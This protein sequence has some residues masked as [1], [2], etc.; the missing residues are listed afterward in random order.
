MIEVLH[1]PSPIGHRP[2]A[3]HDSAVVVTAMRVACYAALRCAIAPKHSSGT[4]LS[5]SDICT[6]ALK[7]LSMSDLSTHPCLEHVPDIARERRDTIVGL[8]EGMV[9]KS[10]SS[11]S[12]KRTRGAWR[13]CSNNDP[14]SMAMASASPL[15][16]GISSLTMIRLISCC[17]R[18][19]KA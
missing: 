17:G 7:S 13:K 4:S 9:G 14:L 19:A 8:C 2:D 3:Q 5:S 12:A 10:S 1:E 15:Y 6:L 18:N 11:C 16:P